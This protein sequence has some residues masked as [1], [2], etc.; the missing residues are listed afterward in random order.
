MIKIPRTKPRTTPAVPRPKLMRF[1]QFL[2]QWQKKQKR[3]CL[4]AI[5]RRVG[6]VIKVI[7]DRWNKRTG[8][9]EYADTGEKHVGFISAALKKWC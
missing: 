3:R 4:Y 8:A 1:S 2:R 6:V 5:L 9:V 7:E